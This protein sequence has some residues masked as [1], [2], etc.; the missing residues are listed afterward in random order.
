MQTHHVYLISTELLPN[1]M[2][3]RF[4]PPQIAWLIATPPMMNK[5]LQLRAML[6]SR[7]IVVHIEPLPAELLSEQ[8]TCAEGFAVGIRRDYPSDTV[9]LNF[10]CGTKLMALA[11]LSGFQAA[12][13]DLPRQFATCYVDTEHQRFERLES[14][15]V[16]ALPPQLLSIKEHLQANG[17]GLLPFSA[18]IDSTYFD[19]A[20]HRYKFTCSLLNSAVHPLLS[21]FSRVNSD[22]AR[23]EARWGQSPRI[24]NTDPFKLDF[25]RASV[26]TAAIDQCV[27]H[28]ML[29]RVDTA[30]Y[31]FTDVEAARYLTGGWLEEYVWIETQR[32][33]PNFD[34]NDLRLGAFVDN[35][36]VE[37]ITRQ[38]E[39]WRNEIDVIALHNHRLLMI[40]CKTGHLDTAEN[41]KKEGAQAAVYKLDS[42]RQQIQRK[43]SEC[44]LV[45]L[46][47]LPWGAA[48]RAAALGIHVVQNADVPHVGEM[49]SEW[50]ETGLWHRNRY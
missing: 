47:P 6:E 31:Q 32:A 35:S 39:K 37:N 46:H 23:Y 45:S 22:K 19:R 10:T 4:S 33:V 24:I 34:P 43:F 26:A 1:L 40:E 5:A 27:L 42:L 3:A 28:G 48:S 18:A 21:T 8:M 2:H 16:Q 36:P 50:A 25:N 44:V 14:E 29:T 7:S 13:A 12:Y 41:V 30:R 49:I 15:E 38:D 11:F 20:I 17:V 9:V